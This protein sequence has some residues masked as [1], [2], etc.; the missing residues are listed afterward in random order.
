LTLDPSL[1]VKRHTLFDA[2]MDS[3]M[4]ALLTDC[5]VIV[6]ASEHL[7]GGRRSTVL[8]HRVRSQ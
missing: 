4:Y 3:L 7:Q 2:V 1:G 5:A 6:M 8:G